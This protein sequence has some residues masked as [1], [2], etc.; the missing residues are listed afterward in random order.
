MDAT[1]FSLPVIDQRLGFDK[2]VKFNLFP[3]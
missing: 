3:G 1:E 2:V